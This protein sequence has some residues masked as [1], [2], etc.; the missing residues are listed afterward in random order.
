VGP[1]LTVD[2]RRPPVALERVVEPFELVVGHSEAFPRV[3]LA[4]PLARVPEEFERI[5]AMP[6]RVVELSE[7]YEVPAH[8][9]HPPCLIYTPGVGDRRDRTFR[10]YGRSS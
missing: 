6:D 1:E 8:C 4:E 10:S 9:A 7:K 5:L 3:G 2:L